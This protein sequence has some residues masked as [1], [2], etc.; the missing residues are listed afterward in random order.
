MTVQLKEKPDL[1][2]EF[3]NNSKICIVTHVDQDGVGSALIAK[4]AI[5]AITYPGDIPTVMVN[6]I[7][8]AK[9]IG[10]RLKEAIDADEFDAVFVTDISLRNNR[11]GSPDMNIFIDLVERR[12]GTIFFYADHHGSTQVDL[13]S[14]LPNLYY[15]VVTDKAADK[16]GADLIYEMMEELGI[17]DL[18]LGCDISHVN[19]ARI[20]AHDYDLWHKEHPESTDITD[21]I[22]V[23]GP[24]KVYELLSCY[25]DLIFNYKKNDVLWSA[26]LRARTQREESLELAR[27]TK[28]I[29][30]INGQRYAFGVCQGYSSEAGHMLADGDT[31]LVAITLDLRHEDNKG[32]NPGLSIRRADGSTVNLKTIAEKLDGGGHEY[33]SGGRVPPE[34]LIQAMLQATI[35]HCKTRL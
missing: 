1:L 15:K 32:F 9:G 19:Q 29:I 28:T 17:W 35:D 18:T 22:T 12:P 13:L 24:R 5:D 11:D 14:D 7:G 16:C 2:M 31:D 3:D 8:Y 23:L 21:A 33:A 34:K 10:K 27:R 25:P 4:A 30:E 20:L 26:I 6:F